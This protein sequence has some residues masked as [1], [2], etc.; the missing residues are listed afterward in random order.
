MA[1]P[2]PAILHEI[3]QAFETWE[4]VVSRFLLASWT[5]PAS[6]DAHLKTWLHVLKAVPL[7]NEDGATQ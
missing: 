4:H 3:L 5:P 7:K 2:L 6:Q 1:L